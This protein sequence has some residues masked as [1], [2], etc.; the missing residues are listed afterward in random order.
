MK[1]SQL[2]QPLDS[3][4]KLL[5]TKKS[6]LQFEMLVDKIKS[7]HFGD[8]YYQN[9]QGLIFV[10]D[11]NDKDRIQEANEELQKMLRMPLFCYSQINKIYQMQ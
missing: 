11:S 6:I 1:L 10:V 7:D 9:T 2:Y 3:I 5:N 4:L 8:I